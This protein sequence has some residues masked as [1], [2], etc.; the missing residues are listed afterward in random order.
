MDG[1]FDSKASLSLP[2]SSAAAVELRATVQSGTVF[3]AGTETA[4][5]YAL[6]GNNQIGMQLGL[7]TYLGGVQQEQYAISTAGVGGGSGSRAK[8]AFIPAQAYDAVAISYQRASGPADRRTGGDAGCL[9]V[10]RRALIAA[11][12]RGQLCAAVV[13]PQV[14][15]AAEEPS[16]S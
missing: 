2:E 15:Q 10:L 16:P 3:P 8:T 13:P 5:V 12:A 9:R 14:A 6:N 11:C 7:R 4:V 1:N